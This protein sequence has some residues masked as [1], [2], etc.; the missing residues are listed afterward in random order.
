MKTRLT[1]KSNIRTRRSGRT[2]RVV[3]WARDWE[4]GTFIPAIGQVGKH[5]TFE[6]FDTQVAARAADSKLS[7]NGARRPQTVGR[8][9]RWTPLQRSIITAGMP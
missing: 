8:N 7:E 2:G 5:A 6:N 4:M 9:K 1:T 3:D